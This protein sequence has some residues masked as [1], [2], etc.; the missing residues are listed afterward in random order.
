VLAADG[1][2]AKASGSESEKP[3]RMIFQLMNV[4][5]APSQ[6]L[7]LLQAINVADQRND[8]AADKGLDVLRRVRAKLTKT[9]E[10]L[11]T[12]LVA[13]HRHITRPVSFDRLPTVNHLINFIERKYAQRL[14]QQYRPK[15]DILYRTCPLSGCRLNRGKAD[16]SVSPAPFL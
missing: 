14:F 7:L 10:G 6:P 16:M 13:P 2:P 9:L 5:C 15:A 12:V 8:P 11:G 4:R 3:L 1:R